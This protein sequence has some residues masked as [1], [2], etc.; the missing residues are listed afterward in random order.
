[1]NPEAN[2]LTRLQMP[3]LIIGL[4]TLAGVA[5]GAVFSHQQAIFFRGYLVGFL[6]CAGI[7]IGALAVLMIQYLTGGA[8]GV[9]IRRP[10]EAAR[11]TLP[12]VAL[13]FV[14]IVLG[15][16]Y[17]YIW[18]N[19]EEVSANHLLE[20]KT[21]YLNL[22]F[23]VVRALFY[24]AV[25]V[26]VATVMSK[27]A[28]R[29]ESDN[30][31]RT[32]LRLRQLSGFGLLG[33]ALTVTFSAIDWAMSLDPTWY[34]TMYGLSFIVGHILS[35]LAFS[36]LVITSLARTRPVSEV[37][38]PAVLRDLGNLLF[39]FIM[40]W[41]YL[42]FSQ[43]LLIWYANLREEVTW[44]LPRMHG[45]WGWISGLLILFHFF[46]PFFL[47]LNRRVKD[48]APTLRLVAGLVIVMHLVDL[49]WTVV[50]SAPRAGAHGGGHGEAAVNAIHW[51][52]LVTALGLITL[53]AGF[54]VS[55]LRTRTLVPMNEPFVQ[56]ALNHG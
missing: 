44:Y 56:E 18:S 6:F 45:G 19:P 5:M 15:I 26:G 7:A 53:W 35:A 55:R 13:M 3:M 16:H 54:F 14:P 52:D 30:S 33:L 20:L 39:A 34:S 50:P 10:L 28:S 11:Q 49:F 24:F 48:Q 22:S 23:F 42:A 27:W 4:M 29:Y 51:I 32:L 12:L 38:L 36:I 2:G 43:F 8:W 41:A 40:L 9:V 21:P 1:M 17:L 25:W 37:M 46:V 31:P 47:L